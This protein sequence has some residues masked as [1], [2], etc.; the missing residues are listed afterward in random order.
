M[1]LT[2]GGNMGSTTS[3]T[4]AHMSG[5]ASTSQKLDCYL[6]AS[7]FLS[8]VTTTQQLPSILDSTDKMDNFPSSFQSDLSYGRKQRATFS[9]ILTNKDT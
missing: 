1:G 7:Q 3:N 4:A 5:L 6:H 2:A 9:Q 8:V